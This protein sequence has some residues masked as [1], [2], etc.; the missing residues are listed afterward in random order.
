MNMKH[1]VCV[2]L[3]LIFHQTNSKTSSS[4][5]IQF[6][7]TSF[8]PNQW[9]ITRFVK[10]YCCNNKQYVDHKNLK[11]EVKRCNWYEENHGRFDGTGWLIDE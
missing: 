2:S 10:I 4:E 9:L 3:G 6:F 7:K 11:I 5:Q 8:E 1:R